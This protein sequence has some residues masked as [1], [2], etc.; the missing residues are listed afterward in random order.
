MKL[1]VKIG[2]AALDNKEL[3]KKFAKTIPSLCRKVTSW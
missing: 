2:G 1:V 3:V